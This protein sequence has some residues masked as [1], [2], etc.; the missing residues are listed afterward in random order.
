MYSKLTCFI[1][2]I[3]S[4]LFNNISC[5]ESES[6][7][8]GEYL[9]QYQEHLTYL[10]QIKLTSCLNLISQ[11]LKGQTGNKY[12]HAAIRKTKLNRDKFY[13]KYTI[14]LITQCINNINE[15]QLDYLLIPENVDAFD[16]NNQTLLNL[17]KL[18]Q[19]ITSLEFTSEEKEVKKVIDDILEEKV[20]KVIDDILE[21]NNKKKKKKKTFFGFLDSGTLMKILCCAMPLVIFFF[22]NSRR[23][24]KQ[25]EAKELDSATKEMLELSKERGKKSPNY[26]ETSQ[27]KEDKEKDKKDNKD[28]KE[29]TD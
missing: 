17:I 27:E 12:L 20:K 23:M 28:Q 26:K 14:A 3:F 6:K 9:S 13:E 8:K 18:E 7:L 15:G 2:I 4:F 24:F 21:E 29:K 10:F 19:E 22:C 25:P 11:S 1:F 16:M 5:S